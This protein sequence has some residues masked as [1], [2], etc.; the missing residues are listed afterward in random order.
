MKKVI[1]LQTKVVTSVRH[2]A[3][4]LN[5]QQLAAIQDLQGYHVINSGAGT[6]KT[7]TLVARLQRIHEVYPSTTVLMLA[8]AK[9]SAQE[10]Q[11]RIGNLAGVTI[12]TFHSLAYHIIKSSGWNFTVDTSVEN[13]ES[14][15]ASLISSRTK[16]T[17]AEVVKSLHKVKG[18]T[19]STLRV[20]Q[21]YLRLLKEKHAVTFDTMIIFAVKLLRKHRG[22]RNYWQN[23]FDFV[24]L[25]EG[26]DIN[27][28]QVELLKILVT[29]TKN[30]C[31]AGDVRQQ[32]YGFRGACGAMEAF[33]KVATIHELTLNYRSNQKILALA[34]SVMFDYAPLVPS[35]NKVSIPPQFLTALNMTDEAKLVTDEIERLHAQG[36]RYSDI[37]VL[38]RSSVVSSEIIHSLIERNIPFTTKS[39]LLNK[40]GQKLWRNII[41]LFK[42]MVNPTLTDAL[43]EILPLFYLKKE[44]IA[45]VELTA[46]E[47]KYTL[48]QSLP[49]LARKPFHHDCIEELATAIET[50]AQF[51]SAK[52]LRH[53][54]KHGL[55]R[56]FGDAMT[57]SIESAI[58]ELEKYPT[59]ADF[60]QH[61]QDIKEQFAQ[62]RLMASKAKDVLTLSTI[63]AAKGCEWQSVF[64]I[65]LADGVIPSSKDNAD[66]A[67]E[68]RLL[69]VGI[70]RA[71]QRLYL[72]YPRMND[73]IVDENK[74][75]RFITG[76]F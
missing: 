60:L 69:Y 72:S 10:L 1:S 33:S 46:V 37:A 34:N 11:E 53:I 38:Y 16:T 71:K 28:A 20:R 67:E 74:P 27:P 22:L 44:R 66:I 32:I 58:S 61:V 56:Y 54:V 73:N 24:Q 19:R 49:L 55:N 6:G 30:L 51:S 23:K 76:L 42:F 5:D 48:L 50:A 15:I 3:K 36:Q 39:P 2:G 68:K 25:D 65:G 29:Q 63:H 47:Q 14:V 21:K 59:I 31:V 8:F 12:S 43:R 41:S 4:T 64:L 57:L 17:M 35:T 62:A 45:E 40:F 52:A 18:A 75:C 9:S 13:Q 7:A 70:T 26:Q